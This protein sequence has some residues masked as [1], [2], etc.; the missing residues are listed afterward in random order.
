M[1]SEM[2]LPASQ[3]NGENCPPGIGKV[4]L[5]FGS[6]INSEKVRLQEM[7]SS[8]RSFQSPRSTADRDKEYLVQAQIKKLGDMRKAQVEFFDQ[9]IME[10]KALEA[11]AHEK[12]ERVTER[13]ASVNRKEEM[14]KQ[15][16]SRLQI[17]RDEIVAIKELLRVENQSVQSQ[18]RDLKRVVNKYQRILV[19]NGANDLPEHPRR[20]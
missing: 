11:S 8:P 13:E 4:S 12:M 3:F 6:G 14:L 19:P 2:N 15:L 1:F 10:L 18:S 16:I 17:E 5:P 20:L 9:K 7:T